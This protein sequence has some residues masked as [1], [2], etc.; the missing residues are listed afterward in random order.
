ML[1][2]RFKYMYKLLQSVVI[3]NKEF[4]FLATRAKGVYTSP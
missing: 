4:W 2:T 1:M 3:Q